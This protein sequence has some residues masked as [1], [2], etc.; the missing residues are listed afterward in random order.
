MHNTIMQTYSPLPISLA[1][2][3]GVWVWDVEGKRYLDALAGIAVTNIGHSHP[4]LLENVTAQL[5]KITHTSNILTVP[6]QA[7]LADRL[8]KLAN[9]DTVFFA[10][11]GAE[12]N[13]CAIKLARL[14]GH[15]QGIDLPTIIVMENSFHGRTLATITASGSRKVQAGFE[16]L[17]QGFVRVP[18]NDIQAIQQIAESNKQIVAVLVEPLQGES[19]IRVAS[20]DYL[21]Q[22]R[23]ICDEN[24]WLMML[25][26]VQ[27]GIGR[28][29]KWFAYQHSD[30][31]PDVIALAKGLGN[32]IPIGACLARGKAHDVLKV[33]NHGT[34]YGGN[35]LSCVA[36]STVLA[37]IEQEG[38]LENATK[39][40]NYLKDALGQRL[41]NLPGVVEVRGQGLM[42]GVEIDRPCREL[43]HSAA[44]AGL[45]LSIAGGS[46]VRLTPPLLLKEKEADQIVDILEK[47]IPEF[48]AVGS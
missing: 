5:H 17:V 31:V 45:L 48:T 26:E 47:I 32:G 24:D 37:V 23:A 30:I 21:K 44:Q 2:G 34:T 22:I 40:G 20:P 43:L 1:K 7:T 28:T 14:Y 10:N 11:S 8:T 25:D 29:G 4:K 46:T 6:E 12:A 38:L 42:L 41:G 13:E 15:N 35:P 9:M 33:G 19:G 3:E 18:F 36:A 16:P 27:T 39:V